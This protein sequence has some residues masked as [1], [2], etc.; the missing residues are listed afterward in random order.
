YG[1]AG[2]VPPGRYRPGPA[3][4]PVSGDHRARRPAADRCR[5]AARRRRAAVVPMRFAA[6]GPAEPVRQCKAPAGEGKVGESADRACRF[7]DAG[8][9]STLRDAATPAPF[10]GMRARSVVVR[11]APVRTA[12]NPAP[13]AAP[14]RPCRAS[15][16]PRGPGGAQ[17]PSRSKARCSAW[18]WAAS[19]SLTT[20]RGETSMSVRAVASIHRVRRI[21]LTHTHRLGRSRSGSDFVLILVASQASAKVSRTE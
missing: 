11:S 4:G 17:P 1:H 8:T 6:P 20:M 13:A 16:P 15:G 7:L 3:G 9:A 19:E 21:E 14:A 12:A 18:L 5:H 2:R 10:A